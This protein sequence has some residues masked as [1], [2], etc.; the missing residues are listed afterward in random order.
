MY[1][2]FVMKS[3]ISFFESHIISR[4]KLYMMLIKDVGVSTF[5]M[6][7]SMARFPK[8][9]IVAYR[10]SPETSRQSFFS[11]HIPPHDVVL[12][13]CGLLYRVRVG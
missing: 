10:H 3:S 11:F 9:T 5:I 6:N 2:I 13:R 1:S 7:E 4:S 12:A 8:V